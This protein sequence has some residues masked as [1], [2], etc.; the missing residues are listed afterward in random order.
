MDRH[1]L[2][3]AAELAE[4]GE[5]FALATVVD[6]RA[7]SSGRV[8][9]A[10]LV[11]ASGE[12]HGFVGGSCTRPTVIEQALAALADGQPRLLVLSPDPADAHR[13][14][15]SFFPMTCHSGG[16]VEIHI[17]PVLPP[18]RL[19]VYGITPAARALSRLGAAMGYRVWAFDPNAE[20]AAF[21]EAEA[22]F[23]EAA[24]SGP[25]GGEVLA[26]VAT[27]GEWDEDALLSALEQSPAYLGVV[28]SARRAEELK[29]FLRTRGCGPSAPRPGC[30]SAR[31]RARRSPSA[32]WRRSSSRARR[33]PLAPPRWRRRPRRRPSTPCAA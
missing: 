29:A 11:T 26:V 1:L 16:S 4:R 2:R 32:S 8:G 31:A 17:Q 9:D 23:N 7:P 20:K 14:G 27:Q 28:V 18:P 22:V 30:A 15:A 19:L 21:P 24:A 33:P 6:R 3:Q 10:C 13:P 5:A 25:A 12:F